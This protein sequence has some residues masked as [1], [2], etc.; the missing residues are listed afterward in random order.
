MRRNCISLLSF[1]L[2]ASQLSFAQFGL[3]KLEKKSQAQ[4][5]A[6]GTAPQYTDADKA[7]MAEI[8][9]RP[10]VQEEIEAAWNDQRKK[11]LDQAYAI[12]QTANWAMSEN[13]MVT[14]DYDPRASRLYNNP[15]MQIYVNQ[16]GQRLVPKDSPNLYTFRIILYPVPAAYSLT[17]GSVYI[18]TGL[19]SMLDSEAQLSYI[20]AHEIAHVEQRHEYN[21]V[22]DVVLETELNKEKEAKAERTKALID[23][24]AALGGG[25]IGGLAK[26]ASGAEIGALVGLGGGIIASQLTVHSGVTETDWNEAEENEADELGTKYMLAQGYDAREVPRLYASLDRMVGKDSRIGMGFLGNPKRVK[27]RS[28]HIQELLNG[29]L[30]DQ[31]AQLAKSNGLVGS[32]TSFPI[33]LAA[34]KRD[35]AIVAMQYD[36]FAMAQA[37]LEDALVQRSNDPTVHFYLSRVMMMTAHTPE[38]RHEAVTHIQDALRLD[39]ERGAIPDLHLE[40]AMSLLTQSNSADKDQVVN[41]LKSYVALYERDNDGQLPNNMPAIIDYFNLVGET[42]WY[43]PPGWY[44]STQMMN[45]STSTTIS[46]DAVVRKALATGG[47]SAPA[48]VPVAAPPAPAP[49][50]A[51]RVRPTAAKK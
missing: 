38:D 14:K 40:L 22:R 35:N 43:L 45:T 27:E 49:V 20:L 7:R 51:P 39:A 21:R 23:V 48:V 44:P 36:L 16:I 42:G 19:M 12:N 13:P 6:N 1:V 17:T 10:E 5:P 33:L 24:G 41:E 26:G 9:Q 37:N 29:P 25:L 31:I 32:G 46:A 3:G 15:M 50:P 34:A 8:A 28:A 18:T 47:D 2:V 30:K 11:D 4:P